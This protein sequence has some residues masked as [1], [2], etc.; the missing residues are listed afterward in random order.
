M[1]APNSSPTAAPAPAATRRA[2]AGLRLSWPPIIATAAAIVRSYDTGVTLRQ[3]FYQ[4][5]AKQ[6]IPNSTSAY[7]LLSDRTSE[8]RRTGTFPD[9]LDLGRKIHCPSSWSSPTE[10]LTNARR[11]YRRDR[12][13][14]QDVSIYLGVE[15]L[16]ITEQLTSWFDDRGIPILALAGFTSTT[17]VKDVQRDVSRRGRPAILLYAGDFDPSGEDIDR[18]FVSRTDCWEDVVRVALTADQVREHELP[19]NPGKPGDSRAAGFI[20]RHGSL[21]QVELDALEPEV[22]HQLYEDA[23]SEYWDQDAYEEVRAREATDRKD[24]DKLVTSRRRRR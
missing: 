17:Y 4:L 15:K 9:L 11:W 8:A 5:V 22:L 3:L 16:G 1:N 18:D 12:T 20:E 23:V 10:F 13:D 21:M 6:L 19:V 7:K 24:L 2:A 14:G